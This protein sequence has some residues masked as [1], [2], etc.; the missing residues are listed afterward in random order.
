MMALIDL[1]ARPLVP[2]PVCARHVRIG[3]RACPFCNTALPGDLQPRVGRPSTRR[4]GRA[5]AFFLG[6]T[7]S[8]TACSS[9]IE[10]QSSS[11]LTDGGPEDDAGNPPPED[12]GM[13]PPDD[14]GLDDGSVGALYGDPPPPLDDAG[15]DAGDAGM[16][17]GPYGS[18]PPPPEEQ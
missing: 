8:L 6:A 12:A 2:C 16:W 14:A 11:G 9:Q 7:V 17:Q 15:P 13:P 10:L 5:A 1:A 4:V 18:P 3:E